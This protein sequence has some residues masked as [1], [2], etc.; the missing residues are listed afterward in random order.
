[1]NKKQDRKIIVLFVLI[2]LLLFGVVGYKAYNDFFKDNSPTKK[3]MSLDLYGYTLSERDTT[4]YKNNFKDLERILNENPIDY[5]E[6]AKSISK[7]FI[8]DVFTLNNK[9]SSTDIGGLEFVHKSLREN[10]KENMGNSLYKNVKSNLD[11]KRKQT[12]PQ[13]ESI[14]VSDVFETKYTYKKKEY[15]AYLV[16]LKW[17]Y[18]SENNYQKSIKLTLINNKDILYIVKG[19]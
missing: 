12:L 15:D 3:I 4:L 2:G 13:V 11:G 18:T 14:E 1:M 6:Y 10:F 16:T 5:E 8:I 19:E 7:L 9:V 17:T